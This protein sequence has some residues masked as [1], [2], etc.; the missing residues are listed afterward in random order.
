MERL[1]ACLVELSTGALFTISYNDIQGSW[2]N[3]CFFILP[4]TMAWT[5]GTDATKESQCLG[6]NLSTVMETL[7]MD[8]WDKTGYHVLGLIKICNLLFF[9]IVIARCQSALLHLLPLHLSCSL[10][11]FLRPWYVTNCRWLLFWKFIFIF[12]YDALVG[13][14]PSNAWINTVYPQGETWGRRPDHLSRK[15]WKPRSWSA[16]T[17]SLGQILFASNF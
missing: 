8:R 6:L 4:L 1:L 14:H 16:G 11:G 15:D 9:L 10:T 12:F 3:I 17:E 5:A 7:G 13:S 2:R